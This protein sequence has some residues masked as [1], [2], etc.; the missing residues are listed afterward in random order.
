MIPID[1]TNFDD[2]L[3]VVRQVYAMRV[4]THMHLVAAKGGLDKMNF[5]D[6]NAEI[7]IARE[8]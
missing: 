8:M 3:V 6:I 4:I 5:E 2:V 1:E 7:A